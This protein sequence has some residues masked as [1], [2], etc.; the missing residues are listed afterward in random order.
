MSGELKHG[1]LAMVDENLRI[2]MV[3]CKDSVYKK[4][5]N[6]LQQ[7]VARGGAP[8]IIADQSVPETDLGGMK[9]ILRI[10]KTVDCVQNVLTVI[11]LQL[12][13]YHI[14]E[15]NGQNVS[16]LPKTILRLFQKKK[17]IH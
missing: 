3:I 14:A 8:F 1:P 4:S 15:L 9:H 7:V 13:A 11:P 17:R 5:L 2:C 16:K 12:L 10:P 6:A